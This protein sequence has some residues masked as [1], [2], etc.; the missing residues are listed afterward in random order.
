MPFDALTQVSNA[1]AFTDADEVSTSSVDLGASTPARRIG[2]GEP[3][4]GVFCVD[5]AAAGDGGS[6]TAS[7]EFQVIS[8]AADT[9]TSPTVLASRTIAGSLLAAGSL[10]VVPIPPG[11]PAQRYIGAKLVLG[12]GDTITATVFVPHPLSMVQKLMSYARGYVV[13]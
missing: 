4:C 2:D 6:F 11:T 10:V 7:V 12:S 9:L 3:M 8:S 13:D 1:Q 5:V